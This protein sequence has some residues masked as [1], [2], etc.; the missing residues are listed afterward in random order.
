MKTSWGKILQPYMSLRNLHHHS[1]TTTTLDACCEMS[2]WST[3]TC[4]LR[5]RSK[6]ASAEGGGRM[7]DFKLFFFFEGGD[8][9]QGHEW[10]VLPWKYRIAVGH[11]AV[12]H[13]VFAK[14]APTSSIKS[15]YLLQV[16][17]QLFRHGKNTEFHKFMFKKRGIQKF[18]QVHL[19][20]QFPGEAVWLEISSPSSSFFQKSL[21]DPDRAAPHSPPIF[22]PFRMSKVWPRVCVASQEARE[23]ARIFWLLIFCDVELLE[24]VTSYRFW[25]YLY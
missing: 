14:N 5:S 3:V 19:R 1:P 18:I 6:R 17:R 7:A 22:F 12:L 10:R 23:N 4:S 16:L 20:F 2:F 25:N 9:Q 15:L 11:G 13:K 8:V 21:G 24:L